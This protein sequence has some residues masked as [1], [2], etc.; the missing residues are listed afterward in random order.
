MTVYA[1]AVPPA[2]RSLYDVTTLQFVN[3]IYFDGNLAVRGACGRIWKSYDTL[4]GT[5]IDNISTVHI[6]LHIYLHL[7]LH[8][9]LRIYHC[10][11]KIRRFLYFALHD[12]VMIYSG[13]SVIR[14]RW[15]SKIWT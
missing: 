9:Y 5:N 14:P 11:A 3:M 8:I 7:Y 13:I 10:I 12:N 2:D 15:D 4:S 1:V 6:Y